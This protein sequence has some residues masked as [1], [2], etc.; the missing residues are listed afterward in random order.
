MHDWVVGNED[1][2]RLLAAKGYHYQFLFVRN[3]DHVVRRQTLAE[4][5]EY[6]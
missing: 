3:A 5:L 4:A 6:L 1:M 2:A